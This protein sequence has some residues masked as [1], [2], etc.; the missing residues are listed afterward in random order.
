[1][2]FSSPICS[3]LF[4]SSGLCPFFL[5]SFER[6]ESPRLFDVTYPMKMRSYKILLL[7]LSVI[8]FALAA[9]MVVQEHEVRVSAVDAANDGAAM[10]LL[11]WDPSDKWPANAADRT[12]APLIPRSSDSGHHRE[13][14]QESRQHDPRS[15]TDSTGSPEPSNPAPPIDLHAD[16]PPSPPPGPGPGSTSPLPTR[17]APTNEPSSPH[18]NTDLIS[19]PGQGPTDNSDR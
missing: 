13:Q 12:N 19:L 9:P 5:I 6:S 8:D 2:T 7:I 17:Q 18:G 14:E 3:P 15:P 16:N 10:S 11:R 1:M 4:V